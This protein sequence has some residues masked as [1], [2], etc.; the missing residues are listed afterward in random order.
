LSI[1][2]MLLFMPLLIYQ[3][4]PATSTQFVEFW[5]RVYGD[6]KTE[7]L[8]SDNIQGELTEKK[9]LKLFE[10]KNG[11]RLAKHKEASVRRNFIERRQELEQLRPDQKPEDLLGHFPEGGVIFRI[12][13]LHC[14]QPERFPIYD[15]HVHRAMAFIQTGTLEEIPA[16]DA[17]KIA[18]YI[19]RYVPFHSTF[20]GI[21]SRSDRA[22]DKALWAF[23]KYLKRPTFEIGVVNDDE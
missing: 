13:W 7:K 15:Q 16:D 6:D 2:V 22:V 21:D 1:E 9:I 14:W 23:G 3:P 20:D 19:H 10:W 4:C 8:Y 17:P 5:R 11:S 18:S 12:F